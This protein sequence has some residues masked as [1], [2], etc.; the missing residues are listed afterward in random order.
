M[1]ETSASARMMELTTGAL[2]SQA[3]SVTAALGVADELASGPR[4][5]E[6]V[7]RSDPDLLKAFVLLRGNCVISQDDLIDLV[8]QRPPTGSPSS[9]RSPAMPSSKPSSG[10]TPGRPASTS[11]R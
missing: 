9:T 11:P 7:A 3:V 4:P 2:L 10:A 5:V 8:D 6:E 1:S